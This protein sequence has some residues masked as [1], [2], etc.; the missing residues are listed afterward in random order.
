MP[1]PSC[2]LPLNFQIFLTEQTLLHSI[3]MLNMPLS[4]TISL[5]QCTGLFIP[6]RNVYLIWKTSGHM[7][8]IVWISSILFNSFWKSFPLPCYP[9]AVDQAEM[10][11]GDGNQKRGGRLGRKQKAAQMGY[12]RDFFLCRTGH[13]INRRPKKSQDQGNLCAKLEQIQNLK[14]QTIWTRTWRWIWHI[15]NN[16]IPMG[17]LKCRKTKSPLGSYFPH[18]LLEIMKS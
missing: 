14:K 12:G 6:R 7:V 4:H 1:S 8:Y 2:P 3:T 17:Y 11:K 18:H 15:I 5:H 16:N 13:P 10:I 9:F